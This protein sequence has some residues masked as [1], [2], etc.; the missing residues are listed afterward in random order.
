MATDIIKMCRGDSFEIETFIP[1]KD[2]PSK[3]Y[4]LTANDVLYFALLYPNQKFE[5]ALLLQGYTLE[6]Q[7]VD[8]GKIIIKIKPNDTRLLTPGIYYYT[9]KLQRGGTLEAIGDFDEPD[10]VRTILERTKFIINE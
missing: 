1:R 7:D 3:P 9:T 5:D 10:E 4:F 8:T 6:E 2:D